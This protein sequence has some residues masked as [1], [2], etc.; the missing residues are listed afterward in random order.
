MRWYPPLVG[1][2]DRQTGQRV[3]FYRYLEG[4]GNV[5]DETPPEDYLKQSENPSFSV[6]L[7]EYLQDNEIFPSD[8]GLEQFIIGNDDVGGKKLYL[9]DIDSYFPL[10]EN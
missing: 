6:E 2:I 3:V 9:I 7:H 8:I 4:A 10:K 5:L 1:L